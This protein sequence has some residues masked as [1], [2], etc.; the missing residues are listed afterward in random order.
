MFYRSGSPAPFPRSC[1]LHLHSSTSP[2]TT[3]QHSLRKA[4]TPF[5]DDKDKRFCHE[6]ISHVKFENSTRRVLD[7]IRTA[8]SDDIPAEYSVNCQQ[9]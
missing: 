2:T 3:L 8:L 9:C 4:I 6:C 7:T 5:N 1:Y